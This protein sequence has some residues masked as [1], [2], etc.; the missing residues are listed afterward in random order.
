MG[1][2]ILSAAY[3]LMKRIVELRTVVGE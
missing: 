2:P 3:G 1:G